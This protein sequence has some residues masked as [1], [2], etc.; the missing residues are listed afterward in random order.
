VGGF[1]LGAL[2]LGVAAILFFGGSRLFSQTARAVVF[3]NGSVAGLDVGAPV[4]FRGVRIGSVQ[5]I[6]LRFSPDTLTTRIPVF[7]EFDADRVSWVGRTPTDTPVDYRRLVDAGLRAQLAPQ[8]FVTGQLRVDLDF[9]PGTPAPLVSAI[10]NVPEIPP[11]QSDLDQ[12]R[13]QLTTLPLHELAETTE[14]ALASLNR[15]SDHLDARL[16]PLVEGAQ[17]TADAA[18]QMLQ[19]T[20]QA[21]LQLQAE[22]TTALHNLDALSSDARRQLDARS[23]DIARTLATAERT[24]R[25]AETLLASLNSLAAPRSQFRGDLEASMRDLSA[26]A[27]SLRTFAHAVERNP[28][29]L[30]TGRSR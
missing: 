26:S 12:L 11:A 7:L 23:E 3:F 17:R 22:S 27:S 20:N 24:A 13:N 1:I 4:T 29:V 14:R 18:T 5:R 16:D 25:Q 19:T 15:L 30:L 10:P 6:A 2:A 21:V 9:R 28:S 8:S